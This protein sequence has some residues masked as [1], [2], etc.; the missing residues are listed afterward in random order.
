MDFSRFRHFIFDLD[1]TL[2]DSGGLPVRLIFGD[3]PH[4]MLLGAERSVRSRLKGTPF[5]REED[6]YNAL[7]EGI[8]EKRN[9]SPDR[10]REWYFERYMPLMVATL[11][12][13]YRCRGEVPALFDRIHSRGGKV[14][15]LSDY[16][17]VREKLDAIGIGKGMAD[18]EFEAP[19]LGGLKPCRETFEKML[20]I[21]GLPR[22][23]MLM[24]GDR[25]DTD[26]LGATGAGIAFFH[27]DQKTDSWKQLTDNI[28]TL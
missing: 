17:F 1:G 4:V 13:H 8:S 10:V 2:Y 21:V 3:L 28:L 25:T 16:G 19:A 24:V 6:Y 7:F 22:E 14:I 5:E 11:K 15:V 23:E 18:Y 26:G 20:G 27:V 9:V 12:K